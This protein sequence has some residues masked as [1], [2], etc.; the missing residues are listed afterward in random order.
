MSFACVALLLSE[1]QRLGV[2]PGSSTG[3]L[4]W[5]QGGSDLAAVVR[6]APTIGGG[7]VEG[8]LQLL[9][10]LLT[11]ENVALAGG[12]V[13]TS[14]LRV[15]GTPTVQ[16]SGNPT[17]GGVV[18]G[19][20]SQQPTGYVVTLSGSAA[21]GRLITR[22]D[23]STLDPVSVPPAATGTRD[24]VLSQAGQTAGDFTT[25]RDLTLTG[26][27]DP[28]TVPPGTYRRF[29][30]DSRTVFILGIPSSSQPTIYNF[31]E[32]VLS[33]S[34]ELRLQGPVEITLATRLSLASG[35]TMGTKDQP[36]QLTLRVA[37][38]SVEM[39]GSSLLYGVVRAPSA[40]VS[41]KGKS[42]LQ[43]LVFCDRILI[44]GGGVVQRPLQAGANQPPVV[45]SGNDQ[46]HT[47]PMTISLVGAATDDQLPLGSSLSYSWSQVSGPGAV[48]F[49]NPTQPS[50]TATASAAGIY[51]LRLAV[52][53]TELTGLDDVQ[54]T[55]NAPNQPPQVSAGPDQT[56]TLQAGNPNTGV[57]NLGGI[58]TDDG[59]PLVGR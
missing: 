13:I 21:L 10:E 18:E 25:L 36:Q 48:T 45:N 56:I 40:L 9:T 5:A 8:S 26:K 30:A 39:D 43:G 14:D 58:V 47:F 52:N 33:A 15:P 29:A 59:L 41:V 2:L 49:A 38:A 28:V 51:V 4:L 17:F 23:P 50:T 3:E 7:R 20:G 22:T 53:D 32:I 44:E 55:L 54:I 11:G 1:F 27:A 34:S 42:L 31:E 19:A 16:I 6:H 37:G 57:A 35:S 12:A 46:T 24:V